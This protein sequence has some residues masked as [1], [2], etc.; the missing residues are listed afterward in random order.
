MRACL[1]RPTPPAKHNIVT[2]DGGLESRLENRAAFFLHPMAFSTAD[3]QRI[4]RL[5]RIELSEAEIEQALAQLNGIFGLIEE[6]QAVS[7]EGV[8][9]MAHAQDL[10]LRLRPDAVTR[11]DQRTEL[12][13]IAPAVQNGLYLVPKVIE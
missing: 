12:Q 8:E 7:A 10:V 13:A 9:P 3:V 6:M 11:A 1:L 2:N 4:A 5:A